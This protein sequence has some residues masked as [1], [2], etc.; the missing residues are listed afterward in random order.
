MNQKKRYTLVIHFHNEFTISGWLAGKRTQ[1]IYED[2]KTLK[3]AESYKSLID[4]TV[5]QAVITDNLTGKLYHLKEF[6]T[7][8]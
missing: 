4:D 1:S 3:E 2:F 5:K 8:R 6:E 7:K